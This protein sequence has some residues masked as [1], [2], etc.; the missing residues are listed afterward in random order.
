MIKQ[1]H[2]CM[3]IASNDSPKQQNCVVNKS[4]KNFS[5]SNTT[6]YF[7]VFYRNFKVLN[8]NFKVL[9][10]NFNPLKQR[11]CC[12][13]RP[14][15][16]SMRSSSSNTNSSLWSIVWRTRRSSSSYKKSWSS[17][18]HSRE[19][20]SCSMLQ[21]FFGKDVMYLSLIGMLWFL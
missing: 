2:N 13:D 20:S 5:S 16:P 21:Q 4:S 18:R 19:T 3:S 1:L 12:R 15:R 9:N 7:N 14:S 17:T 8:R 11:I 6:N 10:R